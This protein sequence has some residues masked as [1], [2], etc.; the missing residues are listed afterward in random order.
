MGTL[1]LQ[2][3]QEII[4][5][6]LWALIIEMRNSMSFQIIR[7]DTMTNF[8]MGHQLELLSLATQY[9]SLNK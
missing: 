9:Q 3:A 8:Q 4:T 7:L 1:Q 6:V 5:M 2:L